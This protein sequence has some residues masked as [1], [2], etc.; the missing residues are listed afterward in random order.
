MNVL[1]FWF[2]SISQKFQFKK[3]AYEEITVI[4]YSDASCVGIEWRD[5]RS[6]GTLVLFDDTHHHP[7]NNGHAY[8][9]PNYCPGDRATAVEEKK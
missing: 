6:S 1:Y 3:R 2:Y 9:C 4:T 5:N 7:S 8:Y